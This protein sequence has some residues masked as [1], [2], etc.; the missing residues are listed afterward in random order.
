MSRRRK[1]VLIV[2]IIFFLLIVVVIVSATRERPV[3]VELAEVIRGDLVSLVAASGVVRPSVEVNISSNV[4]GRIE[5]L[6]VGEGE[7]VSEGDLLL[8]LDQQEFE[9]AVRSARATLDLTQAAL[10][11]SRAQYNRARELFEAEL[12]PRQEYEASLTQFRMD[13][14]RVNEAQA[15]LD[16]S[17]RQLEETVITSP[18]DGTIIRLNVEEGELAVVGDVA[19]AVL[20][21]VADFSQVLVIGE[22]DEA[23]VADIEVGQNVNVEIEAMPDVLYGGEVTEVALA[24]VVEREELA[25]ADVISINYEVTVAVLDTVP[26][27]R[28]GMTAYIDIITGFREDVVMV[29]IQSVVIRPVEQLSPLSVLQ[30]PP[31]VGETE[32]VFIYMGGV[33]E[34]FA[35]QTGLVG[36]DY[37]KIIEGVE[38]AQAVIAGPFTALRVLLSGQAVQP[39]AQP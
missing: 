14:A 9:A 33:A 19:A 2:A 6:P 12:I 23:Q 35:V 26:G 25:A 1:I 27:I 38:P 29:P 32:A 13:Q 39:V 16:L 34:L 17:L 11:Q 28:S 10:S 37:M 22:V 36:T 3:E 8:Q 24:P 21:V 15:A 5:E 31:E 18:I 30:P 20:M 4:A 7:V